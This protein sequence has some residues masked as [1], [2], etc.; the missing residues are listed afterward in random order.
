MINTGKLAGR[1]IF[2]TGA[3]RG[4][5]KS[6]ALKAA[7][8]GANIVIAAKTAEPHPKLPGT[9][10]T[11]A[12]EIEEIGGKALPCVVDVRFETNI[13][14][15]VENAVNKFGGID[16]V[17]NNASAIHLIDTLSTEMKKYDLMNNINTR[18][19]FLVSKACLP[20]LKK[21]SNPH[22]VNISPPLNLKPIWF[23][24]HIAYTISKYGMSM[25]AFGMAE[26][27]KNDG[28]AINTVWPKTAIATAAFEMLVNESN[29]YARKPEIMADAVYALICKDSKSITGK[30]LIDEEILRNEGITDFTDYACNPENKDNLMLDL[31]IDE[32]S[33]KINVLNKIFQ[34]DI[35]DVNNKSNEKIAQIFTVIQANLNHELVNKIGAIF[36]FNVKGNEA[37]TWFLDLKTGDGVAG[38]GKPN[39]SPDATLTMDSENFFAMFS[40]KLKPASAFLMGKLKISGNLQKAMKLEKLMQNLKSKL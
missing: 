32:S 34:K 9:I 5:G 36:Q 7:K 28:I 10:Y 35:N 22:I 2:I 27:F 30:F 13:I 37:G 20:Y 3:S 1:T 19:T 23:K 33:D 39:Q 29:D 25:C 16:I 21:S 31:F 6:I 38:K 17:I 4:I 12:K 14:S 40:G 15:A 8:D 26:E 11:T 24:N 18:G